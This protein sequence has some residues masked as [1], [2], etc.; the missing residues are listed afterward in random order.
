MADELGL[1]AGV[2]NSLVR[3]VGPHEGLPQPIG[4]FVVV[5]L[6]KV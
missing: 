1:G 3:V 2:E 6:M 4:C 5:S